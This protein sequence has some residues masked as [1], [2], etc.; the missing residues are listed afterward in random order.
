MA[1]TTG[2]KKVLHDERLYVCDNGAIYCGAHCGMTAQYTGR[3]RSGRKVQ[4]Y[5][6]KRMTVDLGHG[7][8]F[9]CESCGRRADGT[10]GPTLRERIGS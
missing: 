7:Y 6:V 3:D 1:K 8:D 5:T 10:K 4:E 9:G 2:P